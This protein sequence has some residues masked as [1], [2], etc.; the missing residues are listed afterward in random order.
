MSVEINGRK[1]RILIESSQISKKVSE[2]GKKITQDYRDKDLVII[3]VL[4]GGLIFLA[5]LVR[6]I[7]IEAEID[8]IWASSYKDSMEAGEIELLTDIRIPIENRDVLLVE[9]LIDSGATLDFI[10][11]HILSKH[12]KSLKICA[13]IRKN[14][15]PKANIYIDYLGFEIGDKFIVGYGTDFAEHGRNLPD[16]YVIDN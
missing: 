3:C 15:T 11:Q 1:F 5:D 16:I 6:Q 14:K 8:F 10:R 7:E 2:L 13:L 12:P 9:D 4:K